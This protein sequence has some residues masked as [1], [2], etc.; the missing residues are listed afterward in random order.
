MNLSSLDLKGLLAMLATVGGDKGTGT[1]AE[2]GIVTG[3]PSFILNLGSV[4][5]TS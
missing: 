2:T 4:T 1:Q 3:V 5:Y